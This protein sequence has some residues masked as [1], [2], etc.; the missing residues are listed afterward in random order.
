MIII[1]SLTWKSWLVYIE[2]VDYLIFPSS[3]IKSGIHYLV[4]L[5]FLDIYLASSYDVLAYMIEM[6]V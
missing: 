6:G 3:Q 2:H 1:V 4:L 5:L